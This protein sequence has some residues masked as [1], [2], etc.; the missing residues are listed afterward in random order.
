M[1]TFLTGVKRSPASNKS[2]GSESKE[3]AGTGSP[4][5]ETRSHITMIKIPGQ[6]NERI[7]DEAAQREE[8][9]HK[10]IEA[11]V[12]SFFYNELR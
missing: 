7:E 10:C 9:I 3:T 8:R 2:P 5:T 1:E 6:K 12:F 4:G 11:A